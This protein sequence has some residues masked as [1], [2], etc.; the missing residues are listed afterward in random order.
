MSTSE[1]TA[2]APTPEP[3]RKP[4]MR[5]W[6]Q[7]ARCLRNEAGLYLVRGAATAAGGTLVAYAGVWVQTR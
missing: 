3:R 5:R 6:A 2:K 7:R 1:R 4:S